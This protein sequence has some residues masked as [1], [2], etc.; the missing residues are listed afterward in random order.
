LNPKSWPNFQ[1]EPEAGGALILF[2]ER[3]LS[4]SAARGQ[5]RA[6]WNW[7]NKS[8]SYYFTKAR[9]QAILGQI[10][11]IRDPPA[12]LFGQIGKRG[13]TSAGCVVLGLCPNPFAWKP[14]VSGTLFLCHKATW[15]TKPGQGPQ[16]EVSSP[17]RSP[18]WSK[19]VKA[20][21]TK[22]LQPAPDLSE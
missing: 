10:F 12:P 21:Q 17:R 15:L 2:S 14:P 16:T 19:P 6:G 18:T 8:K 3:G 4:Q 13:A 5:P 20:G 1:L 22:K 7:P 11:D 9:K